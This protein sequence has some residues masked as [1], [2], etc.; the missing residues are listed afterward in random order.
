MKTIDYKDEINKAVRN[1][2]DVQTE[3]YKGWNDDVQKYFYHHYLETIVTD[4]VK[5]GQ[6]ADELLDIFSR[7]KQQIDA[8]LGDSLWISSDIQNINERFR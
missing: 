2:V 3:S 8:L 4:A 1:F 6:K 5:Y 7:S